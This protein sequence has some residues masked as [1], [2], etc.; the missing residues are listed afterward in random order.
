MTVHVHLHPTFCF[1]YDFFHHCIHSIIFCI[2][3]PFFF[4]KVFLSIVFYRF[5][6]DIL[7]VP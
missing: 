4:T 6:W 2:L 5:W 3:Y 1:C 7:E